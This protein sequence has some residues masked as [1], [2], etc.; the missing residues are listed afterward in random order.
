MYE[1]IIMKYL[2]NYSTLR[3]ISFYESSQ[4]YAKHEVDHEQLDHN[5]MRSLS[6]A[7]L[8]IDYLLSHTKIP[9]GT[10]MAYVTW[11]IVSL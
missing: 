2:H 11:K 6:G 10:F 3:S 1:Y 7:D 5:I 8:F 4:A 9:R